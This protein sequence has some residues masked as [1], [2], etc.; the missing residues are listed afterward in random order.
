[1]ADGSFRVAVAQASPV[2]LDR[3]ASLDKA[4]RLI[5]AAADRGAVLVVFG[6]AWLPGYAIH[7]LAPART[8]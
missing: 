7:A 2:V 3:A 4:V 8:D 1:V 5:R 6:E